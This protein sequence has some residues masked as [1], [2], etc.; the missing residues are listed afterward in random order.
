MSTED[1]DEKPPTEKPVELLYFE[2]GSQFFNQNSGLL[3]RFLYDLGQQASDLDDEVQNALNHLAVAT[4]RRMTRIMESEAR[5]RDHFFGEPV[6]SP[7]PTS[8]VDSQAE[9]A[10][11]RVSGTG[12]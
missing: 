9:S 11:P 8:P 3:G 10:A 4:A 6:S 2:A 7:S 1:K 12:E 5:P